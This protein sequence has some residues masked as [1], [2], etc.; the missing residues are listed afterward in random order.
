[1]KRKVEFFVKSFK[2]ATFRIVGW[3]W[4]DKE[5]TRVHRGRWEEGQG[6]SLYADSP[7]QSSTHVQFYCPQ[8]PNGQ[9]SRQQREKCSTDKP[10]IFRNLQFSIR[11]DLFKSLVLSDNIDCTLTGCT[12]H[13]ID[14]RHRLID[15]GGRLSCNVVA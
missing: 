15:G 12:G 1:M 7:S 13:R 5:R 3:G 4:K 2:I 11:R 10:L 9:H 14:P 6:R 8:P